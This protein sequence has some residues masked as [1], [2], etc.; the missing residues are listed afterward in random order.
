MDVTTG[1]VGSLYR[2]RYQVN[3]K[4]N[5]EFEKRGKRNP[6]NGKENKGTYDDIMK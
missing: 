4:Q 3:Q 2:G 6:K 5:D 1:K